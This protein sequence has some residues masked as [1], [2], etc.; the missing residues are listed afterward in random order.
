MHLVTKT[1]V[2]SALFVDVLN[3]WLINVGQSEGLCTYLT[4]MKDFIRISLE[5]CASG[6][7]RKV[8]LDK[9]YPSHALRRMEDEAVQL[10][11]ISFILGWHP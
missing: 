1:Q 5:R 11:R 3:Q 6:Y 2:K 4:R 9:G 10:W 7:P 8:S